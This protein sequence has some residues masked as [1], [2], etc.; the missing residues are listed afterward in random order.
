MAQVA[1][2]V[3]LGELELDVRVLTIV[4]VA[5]ATFWGGMWR[6]GKQLGELREMCVSLEC[7]GKANA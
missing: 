6:V 5:A 1:F 4:T 3:E 2:W 7:T